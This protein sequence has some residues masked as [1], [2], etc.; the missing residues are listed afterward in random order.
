M[1]LDWSSCILPDR[2]R[3]AVKY[4]SIK[5]QTEKE[6]HIPKYISEAFHFV[7]NVDFV[8]LL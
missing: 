7:I 8:I 6:I 3:A 1:A 2:L 5:M 4:F